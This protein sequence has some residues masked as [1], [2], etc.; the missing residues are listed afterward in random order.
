MFWLHLFISFIFLKIDC[1]DDEISCTSDHQPCKNLKCDY[2]CK[3]T[4]HGPFCFC[5][6]GQEI[7]NSTKCVVNPKCTEE[8][9]SG[10][11][12]DQQCTNVQGENKCS[13][14]AGYERINGRCLGINCEYLIRNKCTQLT[15]F[16]LLQHPLQLLQSYSF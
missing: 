7:V 13:C 12:C 3:M 5:P 2:D 4:P 11:V 14:V 8:P 6:I 16:H 15:S 9:S 10:E 1:E